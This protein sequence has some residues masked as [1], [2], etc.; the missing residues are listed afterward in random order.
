[1]AIFTET[2]AVQQI[3]QIRQHGRTAAQH[4]AIICHAQRRQPQIGGQFAAAQQ[5]RDPP[6]IL[7]RLPGHAG[8][9]EQLVAG[10]LAEELMPGQLFGNQLPVG[11]IRRVAAAVDHDHFLEIVVDLQIPD[12]AEK[13]RQP[14]A[15]R[16]QVQMAS[17]QQVIEH[18]G[19]GRFASHQHFVTH[20]DILQARGQRA[21]RHLDAEKL[22]LFLVVGAR[23]AV[24]T[25]QRLLVYFQPDHGE[26][27][28]LE[29]ETCIPGSAKAEQA[30]GPVVDTQHSLPIQIGHDLTPARM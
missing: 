6:L 2:L 3:A 14:G 24:G 12:D 21:I 23:H 16:Q 13:R 30:V 19:A 9:I 25:Q 4:E 7:E 18:Q 28:V 17:R 26:V 15:R 8:V 5:L 10:H 22:Q 20:L 11:E 29:A 1:M 27:A